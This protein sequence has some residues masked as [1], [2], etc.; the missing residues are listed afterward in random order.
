M[1]ARTIS[2]F[3]GINCYCHIFDMSCYE[4]QG[5]WNDRV[6]VRLFI[7]LSQNRPQ[8]QTLLL[9]AQCAEITARRLAAN[10]SSIVVRSKVQGWTDFLNYGQPLTNMIIAPFAFLDRCQCLGAFVAVDIALQLVILHSY[11]V[12]QWVDIN[13]MWTLNVWIMNGVSSCFQEWKP[14]SA[15]TALY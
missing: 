2:K 3:V 7:S 15:R 9:L 11:V 6:S 8:Q 4:E 10:A 14:L 5:L 13:F 12:G 1:V